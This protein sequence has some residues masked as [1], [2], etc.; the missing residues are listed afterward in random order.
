MSSDDNHQSPEEAQLHQQEAA[1]DRRSGTAVVVRA[2][3]WGGWLF[4]LAV[5]LASSLSLVGYARRTS[6]YQSARA[7]VILVTPA[8]ASTTYDLY[9]AGVWEETIGHALAEGRLTTVAGGFA[10]LIDA[11]LGKEK[12]VGV[13]HNL[14]PTQLQQSLVW[15][16]SGN[17]V[18]LMASWTTPEGTSALVRATTAALESGDI[19]HVTIWRGALPPQMVARII[20]SGPA[21]PPALDQSRQAAAQQLLLTRLA[22]GIASG[23]VLLLI[24]EWVQRLARRRT[25]L[26]QSTPAADP[27]AGTQDVHLGAWTRE[28]ARAS[29]Q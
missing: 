19:S 10:S 28:Q 11:Q 12:G 23:L 1:V 17:S 3:R 7:Y 24:W 14:S 6:R 25:H 5:I 26:G 20:P 22:L 21:T 8:G 2:V 16:N 4:V 29:G 13:P 9:E 15:S 27:S 18:L